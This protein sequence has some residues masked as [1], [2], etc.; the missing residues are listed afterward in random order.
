MGR[1]SSSLSV[2]LAFRLADRSRKNRNCDA[3]E[4]KASQ[5]HFKVPDD[6]GDRTGCREEEPCSRRK[7]ASQSDDCPE[8]LSGPFLAH[9]SHP[10]ILKVHGDVSA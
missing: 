2:A 10:S 6:G 5:S 4:N 7:Q 9:P 3:A 8:N 1:S